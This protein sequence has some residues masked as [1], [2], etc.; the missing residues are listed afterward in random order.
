[1][2]MRSITPLKPPLNKSPETLKD[3]TASSLAASLAAVCILCYK[4]A[5]S[6]CEHTCTGLAAH[7]PVLVA[8]VF[9]LQRAYTLGH[10]RHASFMRGQRPRCCPCAAQ[11]QTLLK[12][13]DIILKA[14]C[15]TAAIQQQ[16]NNKQVEKLWRVWA[17]LEQIFICCNKTCSVLIT[18]LSPAISVHI[19]S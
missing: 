13:S 14:Q 19:R 10:A 8:H 5:L 6:A 4:Q 15:A 12:T 2:H 9:S 18:P 16:L 1:M 11:H 7:E 3:F 17:W